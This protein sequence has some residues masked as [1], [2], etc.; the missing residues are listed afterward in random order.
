MTSYHGAVTTES[1]MKMN[2]FYS[3]CTV[4]ETIFVVTLSMELNISKNQK[5]ALTAK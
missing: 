3:P 4:T 2:F 1:V 5:I